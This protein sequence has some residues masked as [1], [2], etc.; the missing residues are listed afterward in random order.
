[1]E[2]LRKLDGVKLWTDPA[3]AR[4]AAIV[5]FQPGALDA[6]K[7]LAALTQNDKI[8]CTARTGDQN[9]GLRLAPHFYNTMEEMDRAVAAIR[10][11]LVAGV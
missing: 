8:I 2:G 7:L 1:M 9:P 5:I 11:Y 6:R 4:S 10:K 3:P